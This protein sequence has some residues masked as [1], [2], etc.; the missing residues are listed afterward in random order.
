MKLFIAIWVSE[1]KPLF[2]QEMEKQSKTYFDRELSWLSFNHRVLQEAGNPAVPLYERIKFLAIWSS[3]LDEFYR[4]RVASLRGFKQLKKAEREGLVRAPGKILKAISKEVL[5]QQEEFGWIFREEVLGELAQ[6]GVRLLRA[7]H[8]NPEQKAF[9]QE[10]F[11]QEF[12]QQTEVQLLGSEGEVPFLENRAL[13]LAVGFAD[14]HEIGIVSIAGHKGRF[15]ALPSPEGEHHFAF[16]DGILRSNLQKLFPEREL[17]GAWS[18]KLSRN[19]DLGL[20]DEYSGNLLEKIKNSLEKRATGDASRFLYDYRMPAP[21][22]ERLKERY[23]LGNAEL[24]SGARYHNFHDFFGFPDPLGLKEWHDPAFEPLA[25]PVLEKATSITD[26][27]RQKDQIMHVPYQ[28][29]APFLRFLEEA[30]E[31]EST[32]EV[33]MT[34]Y[35]VASDSQV[36]HKLLKVLEKGKKVTVFIEAKARFDEASNIFWGDRLEKAGAKVIYSYPGIKVHSK[37]CL[38]ERKN[39]EGRK[40]RM[41][42]LGTGNFN[43]KT[44][45]IYG[46]HGLFTADPEI[47]GDISQVFAV[48]KGEVLLP[49]TT[50][51]FVSPFSLR[52]GFD[53]LLKKEIK[54]AKEGQDAWA[55]LKMNSLQDKEMIQRLYEASQTGVKIKL[56]VRGICCLK[57][58]IKGLSENIE[59]ISIVD[60]FLEHARVY[61]FCN[62]GKETMYLASADWMTRNL[63]HRVEVA[64]PI[65]DA[66]VKEEIRTLLDLQLADNQKARIINSGQDNF[67][68][69]REP[70]SAKIRAQSEIYELLQNLLKAETK[71]GLQ[72]KS[73]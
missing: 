52:K 22:L 59:V 27:V 37:L 49:K 73:S 6:K 3:N 66:Q 41:A 9:A 32:E 19:A 69:K 24:V 61:I 70:E 55:I 14:S 39:S 40:E 25:H 68:V 4:V 35:R 13:Y 21:M 12:G 50:D 53:K 28:K 72:T 44:A 56:I 46:D 58:G 64:F 63:D 34:L 62:G 26:I 20:G 45:R 57:P 31:D 43:E 8:F 65:K 30:A 17:S 5:R 42:Y 18:V 16:S 71:A 1:A 54:A 33:L 47:C 51:C 29:F 67:F 15:H 7:E 23:G 60:R 38:I 48:L 2:Q 11:S 36:A 10:V